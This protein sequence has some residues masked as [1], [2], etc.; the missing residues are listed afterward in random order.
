MN[1][2]KYEGHRC[3]QMLQTHVLSSQME[4]KVGTE[5]TKPLIGQII[6]KNSFPIGLQLSKQ[7]RIFASGMAGEHS[8]DPKRE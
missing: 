4:R 1:K 2:W 5:N 3:K 6:K 7:Y 8:L